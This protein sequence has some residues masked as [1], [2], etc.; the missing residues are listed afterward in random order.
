MENIL[1]ILTSVLPFIAVQLF[2]SLFIY[3]LLRIIYKEKTK[4]NAKHFWV[5]FLLSFIMLFVFYFDYYNIPSEKGLV[6]D[7]NLR[8]WIPVISSFI[9]AFVSITA[10]LL[11]ISEQEKKTSNEYKATYVPQLTGSVKKIKG[12]RSNRYVPLFFI[13]NKY[14]YSLNRKPL[15]NNEK[16][17][18][19]ISNSGKSELY[20]L[21]IADIETDG[22]YPVLFKEVD[23]HKDISDVIF[24]NKSIDFNII[25]YETTGQVYIPGERKERYYKLKFKCYFRNY[26]HQWY[27]QVFKLKFKYRINTE[28]FDNEHKRSLFVDVERFWESKS[29]KEVSDLPWKFNKRK[30]FFK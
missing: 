27:Y 5:F 19:K 23:K 1:E 21:V 24:R 8:S 2:A 29:P 6:F 12:P 26:Y 14:S 15:K 4:V 20:Q 16:I 13:A 11:S 7:Q 25:F 3:V 17:T 10:V 30:W 28:L 9:A 22:D 18:L